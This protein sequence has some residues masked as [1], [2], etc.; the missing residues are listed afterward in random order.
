MYYLYKPL[1]LALFVVGPGHLPRHDDRGDV[2]LL[3]PG[4]RDALEP[5]PG[6]R[7]RTTQVP[8]P[9]GERQVRRTVEV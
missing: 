7:P 2:Q 3:R 5:E 1:T 8:G 6:P 4:V 9:S